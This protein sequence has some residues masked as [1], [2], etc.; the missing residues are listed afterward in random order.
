MAPIDESQSGGQVGEDAIMPIESAIWTIGEQ[1]APLKEAR[2]E[3][4]A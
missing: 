2:L 4:R 3:F 1:P